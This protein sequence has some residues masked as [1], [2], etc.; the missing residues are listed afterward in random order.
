MSCDLQCT[1][2]IYNKYAPNNTP[3]C[4]TDNPYLCYGGIPIGG[5]NS[6]PNF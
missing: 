3:Q 1:Q 5:R 6:D 4:G 2:D